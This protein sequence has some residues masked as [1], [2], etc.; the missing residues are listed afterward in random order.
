MFDWLRKA[1]GAVGNAFNQ[2][3]SFV[4]RNNPVSQTFNYA[5]QAAA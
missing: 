4:A 5:S 3:A 1:A 2:G